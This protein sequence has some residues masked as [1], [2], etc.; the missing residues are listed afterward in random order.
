MDLVYNDF[1]NIA[2]MKK[3]NTSDIDIA[4]VYFD[5]QGNMRS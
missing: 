5:R 4:Q 2:G 1:I 3:K